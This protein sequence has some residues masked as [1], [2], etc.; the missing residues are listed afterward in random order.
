MKKGIKIATALRLINQLKK[1]GLLVC[2]VTNASHDFFILFFKPV[3][4]NSYKK[5][6][7]S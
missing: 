5:F 7:N 6:I 1:H 3:L 2:I 4:Y